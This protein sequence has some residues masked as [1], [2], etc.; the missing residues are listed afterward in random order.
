MQA[1]LSSPSQSPAMGRRR[2]KI[3]SRREENREVRG[4]K[5]MGEWWEGWKQRGRK[6]SNVSQRCFSVTRVHNMQE[7]FWQV[8]LTYLAWK[9]NKLQAETTLS[10]FKWATVDSLCC[11]FGLLLKL[12][13]ERRAVV[14]ERCS[15][16]IKK[17]SFLF[18]SELIL[19]FS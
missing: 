19:K 4:V 9:F 11:T 12:M 10:T 17:K 7:G 1:G 14:K 8:L 18:Q 15:R 3:Q 6:T 5:E 2:R 13:Q 16:Q